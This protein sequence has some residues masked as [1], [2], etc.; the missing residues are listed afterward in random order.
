MIMIFEARISFVEVVVP[1]TAT[2]FPTARLENPAV[3]VPSRNAVDEFVSIVSVVVPVFDLSASV[4]DEPLVIF[5]TDPKAASFMSRRVEEANERPIVEPV[6][7]PF[8]LA[9]G[10]VV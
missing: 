6:R 2:R 3:V 7:P 10:P 5:D 4:N 9:G 1:V 8:Q